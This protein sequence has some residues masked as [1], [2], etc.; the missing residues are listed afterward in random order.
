MIGREMATLQRSRLRATSFTT[1]PNKKDS[2]P[3][4]LHWQ[5]LL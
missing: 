3:C 4:Q 2:S 5:G 1:L